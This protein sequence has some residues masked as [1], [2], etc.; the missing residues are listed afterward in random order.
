M[1]ILNNNDDNKFD[2]KSQNYVKGTVIG[3]IA[4]VVGAY[5][6]NRSAEEDAILN[7]KPEPIQTGQLIALG[8]T[9]LGLLRQIAELGKPKKK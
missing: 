6:Y 2:W 4:G 9:T 7:G 1:S 3:L 5:L 8:L